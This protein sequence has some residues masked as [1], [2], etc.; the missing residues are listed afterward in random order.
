MI[1]MFLHLLCFAIIFF[2][3]AQDRKPDWINDPE[4]SYPNSQYMTAVGTGDSRKEAENSAASNLSN[5]FESKI[6]SEETIN[7][8]YQELMKSSNQSSLESQTNINKNISVSSEQTLFNVRYPESYTDNLGKVYVLGVIEREPTAAIY[9]NKMDDNNAR[10]A[11]FVKKYEE[12]KDPIKKY[13]NISAALVTAKVNE[14]LGQQL[15]IIMPGMMVQ[16]DTA[17][18]IGRITEKCTDAQKGIPFAVNISGAEKGDVE[19]FIGDML[20][21]LGFTV[22]EKGVLTITGN[23]KVEPLDLKNDQMKFARWSYQLSVLDPS[24]TAIISL[25]ENGREAHVTYDEA[26]A[27]AMRTM[28]DKIKTDFSKKINSYFDGL[29]MK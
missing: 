25:S 1:S 14:T 20:S 4:K 10:V 19:G 2:P 15:Q 3:K 7:A 5:I 9:K 6:K 23:E 13:A 16:S 12:L 11:E 8:R 28:R 29:V 17:Y 27:R 21:G 24:G 26:V 18:S 22:A